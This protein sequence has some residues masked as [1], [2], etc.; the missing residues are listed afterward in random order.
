MCGLVWRF[1]LKWNI[2]WLWNVCFPL[3]CFNLHILPS[4]FRIFTMTFKFDHLSHFLYVEYDSFNQVS[5]LTKWTFTKL[6][7][8]SINLRIMSY[9][10][11][12]Q[13]SLHWNGKKFKPACLAKLGK[14]NYGYHTWWDGRTWMVTISATVHPSCLYGRV[15]EYK[16]GWSPPEEHNV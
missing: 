2:H 16:Q 14:K 7:H 1:M 15:A 5:L 11:S 9:L 4:V 8:C 6:K 10:Q 3:N 12:G 13:T